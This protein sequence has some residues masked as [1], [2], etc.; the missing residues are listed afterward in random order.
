MFFQNQVVA[1]DIETTGFIVISKSGTTPETLSQLGCLINIAK[2]KN[3]INVFYKNTLII[4]EFKESPLFK[5]I[6][7]P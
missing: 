6:T 7:S 4:T 2:E 3:I 1:L 5:I